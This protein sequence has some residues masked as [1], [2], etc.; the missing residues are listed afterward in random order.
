MIIYRQNRIN[1][2]MVCFYVIAIIF[3]LSFIGIGEIGTNIMIPLGIFYLFSSKFSLFKYALSHKAIKWYFIFCFFT[4]ISIVYAIDPVAAFKTQKK[5]LIVFAFSLIVFSYAVSSVRYIYTMYVTN[6]FMLLILIIY[7]LSLG[8]TINVG[9]ADDTGLNANTYGYYIFNGLF[10]LFILYSGTKIKKKLRVIFLI[11]LI[12]ACIF[13]LWIIL[14]SASR[15]ASIITG[16]L[17]IGNIFIIFSLSKKG[18]L[19]R[20]VFFLFTLLS[21]IYFI[22]YLNDNYFQDSYLSK[23]FQLLEEV[24]TPRELLIN[25]AIEI[26]I[27]NPIIGVGAGNFAIIQKT[28]EQGSFSH[29]TFTEI[30]ANFGLLGLVLYGGFF[31]NILFKLRKLFK[32]SDINTKIILYQILLFLIAFN[33]YST[34]YVVYLSNVFM[35]L[36]F[37][38]YAH[39]L[40][41]DRNLLIKVK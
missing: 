36:L 25:N 15:G 10:S 32:Y 11:F 3:L 22:T 41:L 6:A 31:S 26:G 7:V 39:I 28:Y 30:F 14:L 1:D 5:M 19:K 35:H 40:M 24:E 27:R 2:L 20:L 37:V 21:L 17:I 4:S 13:S 9:R 38:V 16:F 12:A 34:L 33:I 8:V 18:V 23:R 29:N